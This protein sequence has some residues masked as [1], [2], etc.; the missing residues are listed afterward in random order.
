MK[1]RYITIEREYGSGGTEIAERLAQ[2]TGIF[3]YGREILEKAAGKLH[4]SVEEAEQYEEKATNSFLY[5]LVVMA[6][7]QSQAPDF[8]AM[9]G[10]LYVEE[11]N[12]ITEFSHYGPAVFVGHCACEALKEQQGV[13]RVFIRADEEFKMRRAI[14]EYGIEEKNAASVCRR[15]D[16]KR[17]GYYASHTSKKW[18]DLSNYDMVLDSSRIGIDGCVKALAAVYSKEEE[19][20][21][22]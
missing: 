1:V 3:C 5:S 12:T 4:I 9:E 22:S 17:A 10:K 21:G 11:H 20:Q 6:Q 7:T 15:Y 2:K 18:D 19:K 16:K 8:L 14:H 13:L